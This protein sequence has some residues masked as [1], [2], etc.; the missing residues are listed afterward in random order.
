MRAGRHANADPVADPDTLGGELFLEFKNFRDERA[1]RERG[2]A[3]VDGQRVRV[4]VGTRAQDV[5]EC[6]RGGSLACREHRSKYNGFS[7]NRHVSVTSHPLDNLWT[8]EFTAI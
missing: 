6:A 4:P 3:V 5:Q 2:G 7:R 8:S 1:V